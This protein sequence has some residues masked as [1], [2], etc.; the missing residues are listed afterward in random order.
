MAAS[1]KRWGDLGLILALFISA[2]LMLLMAW[3][4]ENLTLYGDYQ[5]NFDLAALSSRGYLPFIH[6]WSEYAPLFPFLNLVPYWLSGGIFK[7][8]VLIAGLVLLV[9]EAG[10]LALL[11]RLAAA[12]RTEGQAARIGWVYIALF[13][14]VF[15]WLGTFD[16]ITAFFVLLALLAVQRDRPW[17]AGL[18]IGLGTMTKLL[19]ILLLAAVWRV[20]GWR[21]A[22]V[23]GL[24]ALLVIAAILGPLLALSP[25]YTLASLQAQAGK[26]SWE[27]MWALLDGN[28]ANTGNFGPIIDRFDPAKAG[29]M[30]HNPSRVSPWLTAIPFA[31]LGLFLFTRP[32]VR[33]E[34][35]GAI[36]AALTFVLFCLWSKGWSP[37]WQMFLI[38]LLFLSL[39]L[40]RA[41][42]FV[43]VLGFVNLLEWPVILSRGL[44]QA[45][46]LTILARTLLFVLLAWE[47]YSQMRQPGGA[48][49]TPDPF[50]AR[51]GE[52]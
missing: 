27:T 11:Y 17:L 3:P 7:N 50:P 29:Q 37:Q 16:A 18:A 48:D 36:F 28:V 15:I 31:L 41:V 2:R 34:E 8:Y 39:P 19:P 5:Y 4:A 52:L 47:L 14:P 46:P 1:V 6:Y 9:F 25:D 23:S 26:S 24:V 13:V 45:L 51:E 21:A 43:V 20:R 33:G 35:D 12:N 32:V 49:L 38:P 10:A 22:L 44:T 30:L 42:M 40:R